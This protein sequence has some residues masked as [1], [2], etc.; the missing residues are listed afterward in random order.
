[1][2]ENEKV[3]EVVAP[4]IQI[5]LL[6]LI[7]F[8]QLGVTLIPAIL[9]WVEKSDAEP[10][11]VVREQ[12]MNIR[13]FAISFR[14]Q[15][16]TF[17]DDHSVDVDDPRQPFDALWHVDEPVSFVGREQYPEFQAEE[18]D[19]RLV[20]RVLIGASAMIL[21][22]EMVFS[23]EVYC[24]GPLLC[25]DRTA[26]RALF[27][28]HGITLGDECVVVRWLHSDGTVQIGERSQLFGRLSA[29]RKA[30]IGRDCEFE[31]MSSPIIQF[32]SSSVRRGKP[33]V[34]ED[35]PPP[36]DIEVIDHRT[37]RSGGDI[38]VD[39]SS[40]VK[41]NL[42]AKK[43][44][45][46]GIQV[47]ICGD[48]KAH[49]TLEIG[50][51]SIIRGAIVSRGP[52]CIGDDCLVKGPVISETAIEIASGCVIGTPGMPT[53]VSAPRITAAC[54]TQV[55]GSIWATIEGRVSE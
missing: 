39:E 42:I 32:S 1:L 19:A 48:L 46:L 15:V 47:E 37:W 30:I 38:V 28:E 17:F 5:A 14:S 52:I 34:R 12:D 20:H 50:A 43:M 18:V 11:R 23:E 36:S 53:T 51:G 40:S 55:S 7:T 16:Q 10:L 3:S 35:W 44:I 49:D 6:F 25:G 41:F 31:R 33:V 8:S 26:F 9:E 13:H 54:G 22:G 2:A 45:R 27:S 21:P 4:L 29:N 24:C